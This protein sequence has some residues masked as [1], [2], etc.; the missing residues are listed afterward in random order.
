M[1]PSLRNEYPQRCMI[2]IKFFCTRRLTFE[3]V[4]LST[5]K[6]CIL[7]SNGFGTSGLIGRAPL[8][9]KFGTKQIKDT[10]QTGYEWVY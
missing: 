3:E 8:E 2:L 7:N 5:W 6:V 9:S 10:L 1:E 4:L